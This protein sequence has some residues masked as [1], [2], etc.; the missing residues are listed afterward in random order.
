[1]ECGGTLLAIFLLIHFAELGHSSM[2]RLARLDILLERFGN[3]IA[4]AQQNYRQFVADGITEGQR[5]IWR[6]LNLVIG[7]TK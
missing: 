5:D 3:S 4:S 6:Y 2:P 1:V 7:G